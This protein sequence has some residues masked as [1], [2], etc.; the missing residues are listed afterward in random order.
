M[1]VS[2][3]DGLAS[4]VEQAIWER[5]A[6]KDGAEVRFLCPA[7][8][9][10]HPSAR[11]HPEKHTWYCD[12]CG[13]GGGVVDLAKLL[14]LYEDRSNSHTGFRP[15]DEIVA[16]YDYRDAD[17]ALV[18]QAVRYAAP[19]E[20]RQ[21]RPDGNG[22][23][24]RNL[25]G[26]NRILYRLP[27]LLA[28]DPA[29]T[30]F[31]VEGE[32]D[33]DNLAAL[34]LVA[35]TNPMGAG[36]WLKQYNASL[37][38][39]RVV[40]L[41]D[42][43]Q[44]GREHAKK[45]AASVATVAS[46][47]KTIELPGLPPKGDVSDWLAVGGTAEELDLLV[48]AAAD[49]HATSVHAAP[50]VAEDTDR[51]P[52]ILA[53]E[54]D[55]P[56]IT[57]EAWAAISAANDPPFLF[58]HGGL[59]SR[60]ETDDEEA[61]VI[62]EITP[63][64]ARYEL[65]RCARF[66]VEKAKGKQND[67]RIVL[68][69]MH[70]VR[71]VLATP[72]PPLPVLLRI[73][74]APVFAPDG[75]LQTAPGY[76]AASRTIYANR[77]L[78]VPDVPALPTNEDIARGRALIFD[79]LVD[80]PFVSDAEKANAI[81]LFLL[82]FVR[83]LISGPTPNHLIEA[84]IA[85]SGKGLLADI[86][87]RPATGRHVG[88]IPEARDDD[89]WRKRLTARLREARSVVLI[90]NV[91]HALDSGTL[92]AALTASV[93]EDRILGKTETLRVPIRCAWVTT[94]NNPTMSTEIARRCV[95][96]RLDPR[97]DRPWMRNGWKHDPLTE[98]VDEH[99]GDLV[100][101]GLVLGRAWLAAGRPRPKVRPLGSYERWSY[102]LGGILEVAGIS[103]FLGNLTDFYEL[104]DRE[105]EVWRQ[106]VQA[107][108]E[109]FGQREVG[110]NE[111][112]PV[113]LATDG[114]QLGGRSE[115]A[116]QTSFGM[117]LGKK[118]DNVIGEYRIALVKTE[119]KVKRWQLMPL[120]DLFGEGDLGDLGGPFGLIRSMENTNHVQD[121]NAGEKVP[122]GTQGPPANSERTPAEASAGYPEGSIV[123]A[124]GADRRVLAVHRDEEGR[125]V[126]RLEGLEHEWILEAG[127]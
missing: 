3:L 123:N 51:R 121:D 92:A 61:P 54:Q 73:V 29:Q 88:V 41:P 37:K 27:E 64:R 101:A 104:S 116:Q 103:S 48:A 34:G 67:R 1:A 47:V 127:E 62:S 31:L 40:I 75:S 24:I 108:W 26:V 111:I 76:H 28:A 99:R 60:L 70:V 59:P 117:Q 106:F 74:E 12:A 82:P 87:L 36:K 33:A 16:T 25:K 57:R 84:P 90:D 112:F 93:W 100:W 83:D 14:G 65:A 52:W 21:R 95:R 105:G 66:F 107:W 19:K 55:L 81:A 120:K 119:H 17:G 89:E 44:A 4:I 45:V 9:D 125:W 126:Y 5:Q 39:R 38:G 50:G 72:D 13:A 71:N 77:S 122:I 23:W 91:T 78:T 20:F 56:I 58:R 53:E 32:K 96:I 98:W 2:S 63:D 115:R 10:H 22:G 7:H 8:D 35:T 11:W 118:R 97:I 109:K 46:S 124:Q 86:L 85:G 102:V 110:T 43:D 30:V 79:M 49:W 113:A 114:L 94:A 15:D 69:P 6:H 80:F 18:F 42:N 68:P